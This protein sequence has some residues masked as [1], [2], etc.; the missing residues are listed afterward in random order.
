MGRLHGD[1]FAAA[2]DGHN[3]LPAI[4]LALVEKLLLEWYAHARREL[5]W[6]GTTDPYAVLVSEVML[7]QTQVDRVVRRY[8]EWLKRWPTAAA[9]QVAGLRATTVAYPSLL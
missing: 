2:P 3:D 4:S 9:V 7:Q 5:P 1:L 8:V 6:R